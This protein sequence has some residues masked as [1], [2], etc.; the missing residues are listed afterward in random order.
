[1]RQAILTFV[2]NS[3]MRKQHAF[4]KWMKVVKY[5]EPEPKVDQRTDNLEKG[6]LMLEISLSNHAKRS[7]QQF[8]NNLTQM[9]LS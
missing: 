7:K 1:M 9:A 2:E 3:K 5:N 4:S 6:L 8:V